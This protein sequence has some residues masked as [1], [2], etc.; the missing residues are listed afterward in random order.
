MDQGN[1]DMR[2]A[3][4]RREM[5]LASG[6]LRPPGMPVGKLAPDPR[7]PPP[8]LPRGRGR[9]AD[10]AAAWERRLMPMLPGREPVAG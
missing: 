9:P 4:F 1:P 5:M 3:E 7:W 6:L 2:F 8:P 10:D